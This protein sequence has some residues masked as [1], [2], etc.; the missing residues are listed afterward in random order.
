M[1]ETN[2][3]DTPRRAR[4]RRRRARFAAGALD[5][6]TTPV[7]MK[8]GRPGVVLSA[9]ARPDDAR[10]VAEAIVRETTALGVRMSRH[11]AARAR[12]A[13]P[14]RHGRR[15]QRAR[16]ARPARRRGRQPRARARRLRARRRRA[17]AAGQERLGR[18]ARRRG[19]AARERARSA[20][21]AACA[22]S[23]ASSSRSRAAS[24]P[25]SSPRSPS[26]RWATARS[27][28]PP[29]P[30][31]S[32][33]ASSTGARSVAEAVGIAH[34]IITTDELA[35]PG[36]RANGTD[37]CYHCKT[38]L[39]DAL[40]ALAAGARLRGAAPRARTPTTRATG[41]PA[42]MA[43]GEH[44]VVHPL[45]E[46]GLGKAEVR[47]LAHELGVPERRQAR[48]PVPGLAHP[49]RHA[50]RPGD[51][52]AHRR[53]RA[54]RARARLPACCACATTA[55]SASS[56]CPSPTSRAPSP[57]PSCAARS[58]RRSARRLRARGDRHR[59]VQVGQPQ[60][61]VRRP[62]VG[63]P[64]ADDLRARTEGPQPGP[65]VGL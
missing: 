51:A 24:T 36:Y 33:P 2:L 11:R 31:R 21:R 19:G 4:A 39:Y 50:G 12:A 60:R 30:P 18:G 16:Q 9:L 56:S 46:A 45:L 40:A 53:G 41:G 23:A 65:R 7:Q 3:D 1:I 25:R 14:R 58:A 62:P 59:A 52:R 6:W 42:S 43:A 15:R 13:L 5:V 35:R 8:K 64:S 63:A 28:S 29:S 57:T 22:S 26:A 47:A 38:E 32:R 48:E 27:P 55:S 61:H 34:E 20:S 10:A 37:R 54:G 44:G 49:V 17:R